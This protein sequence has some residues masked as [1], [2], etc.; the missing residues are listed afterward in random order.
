MK[1]PDTRKLALSGILIALG[2]VLSTFFVPI[3]GA[4][5]FPVQH[6]LNVVAA[7]VLGPGYA[8][9]CAFGISLLR[10][11]LGMGTFLAFPGSMAGALL[12]SV[13]YRKTHN[14]KWA[15]LGEVAG[16]GLAG[17]LAA[18]PLFNVFMG[19]SAGLL[20]FVVPFSASSL[21]GAAAAL[22]ILEGSSSLRRRLLGRGNEV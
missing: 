20:F 22:A 10:N 19:G 4:K 8:V 21:L 6:L 3:G 18:V 17:S 16:T 14:F 7:S 2:I 13:L 11:L 9:L 1:K 15:A 5:A 12:A